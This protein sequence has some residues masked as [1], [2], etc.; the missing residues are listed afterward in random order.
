MTSYTDARHI[1]IE[2]L[3]SLGT[4]QGVSPWQRS[5]QFCH[6]HALER[7]RTLSLLGL[8]VLCVELD[9]DGSEETTSFHAN[10]LHSGSYD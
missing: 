7:L 3:H 5:F 8:F 6:A 2:W 1:A 4:I 9:G 10:S